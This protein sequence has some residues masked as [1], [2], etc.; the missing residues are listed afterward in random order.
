ML[1]VGLAIMIV[2]TFLFMLPFAINKYEVLI[3]IGFL[4][5]A[6]G[7]ILTVASAVVTAFMS[8]I[9]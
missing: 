8:A 7:G 6:L 1:Y 3:E 9:N 4:T 2:G 5:F